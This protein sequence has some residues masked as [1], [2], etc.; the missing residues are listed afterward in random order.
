MLKR[1][2]IF[3]Q[4]ARQEQFWI[5][6]LIV[7]G[8]IEIFATENFLSAPTKRDPI[9]SGCDHTR[10]SPLLT[11]LLR[12]E[13]SFNIR[14]WIYIKPFV[15]NGSL[16]F[17]LANLCVALLAI[18]YR[19]SILSKLNCLSEPVTGQSGH[20]I[21]GYFHCICPHNFSQST[22]L[23]DTKFQYLDDASCDVCER[24]DCRRNFVYFRYL[25]CRCHLLTRRV[26]CQTAH[27]PLQR[28][29]PRISL[30]IRLL[31]M[32]PLQCIASK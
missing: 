19:S 6:H 4:K 10:S 31:L 9:Y 28:G 12:H 5:I 24:N 32:D 18:V 25:L 8:C 20:P 30:R 11:N 17:N 27:F 29:S 1:L 15:F 13:S 26:N 7:F 16:Q 21:G 23:A 14:L 3:N 22:T 2:H